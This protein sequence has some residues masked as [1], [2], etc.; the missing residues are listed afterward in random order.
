LLSGSSNLAHI[1]RKTA[2]RPNKEEDDAQYSDLST[3]DQFDG[4]GE[5]RGAQHV[6]DWDSGAQTASESISTDPMGDNSL[7]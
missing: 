5:H 2:T 1:F 3:N 7:P 4:A 6:V